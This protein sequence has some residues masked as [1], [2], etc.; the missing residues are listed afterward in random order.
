MQLVFI[1]TGIVINILLESN[2]IT[3]KSIAIL[4]LIMY[5]RGVLRE[6]KN[7]K[8]N[9]NFK[10]QLNHVKRW[11]SIYEIELE[12]WECRIYSKLCCITKLLRQ[13][14]DLIVKKECQMNQQFRT[15]CLDAIVNVESSF[16]ENELTS[17]TILPRL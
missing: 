15:Q 3:H 2:T 10:L 1:M 5:S 8:N 6:Y 16:K 12:L 11:L 14:Q 7:I 13:Y 9:C 17:T 4:G